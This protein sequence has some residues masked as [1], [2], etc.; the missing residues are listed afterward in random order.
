[1]RVGYL[2]KRGTERE[3]KR[4]QSGV[5]YFGGRSQRVFSCLLNNDINVSK[6]ISAAVVCSPHCETGCR[7]LVCQCTRLVCPKT[8][9]SQTVSLTGIPES[10]AA[11][12][13]EILNGRAPSRMR[14]CVNVWLNKLV[15]ANYV[16]ARHV[17]VHADFGGIIRMLHH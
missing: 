2:L 8:K 11:G 13:L 3:W 17:S 12:E 9:P 15:G 4:E 1:M 6:G 10:F 5:G 7:L 14:P 16:G